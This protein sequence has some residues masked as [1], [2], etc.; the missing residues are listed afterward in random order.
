MKRFL[1]FA[2]DGYYPDGGWDDFHGDYDTLREA[3]TAAHSAYRDYYHVV[4]TVDK[5]IVDSGS[6]KP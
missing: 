1:V 5:R 6:C 3:E 4:D 2:F